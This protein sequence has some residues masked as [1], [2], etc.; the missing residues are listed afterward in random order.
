ML[1]LL[2]RACLSSILGFYIRWLI[3]NNPDTTWYMAWSS[4]TV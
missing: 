4:I 1:I 2:N 3:A